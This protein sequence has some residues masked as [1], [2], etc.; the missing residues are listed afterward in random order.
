MSLRIYKQKV[1]QNLN[2]REIVLLWEVLES[3]VDNGCFLYDK[4]ETERESLKL[5]EK[6][7][8]RAYR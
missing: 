8:E 2:H 6:G 4:G 7:F 3:L 5:T 1:T